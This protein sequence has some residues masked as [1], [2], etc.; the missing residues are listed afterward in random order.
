MEGEPR[1]SSSSLCSFFCFLTGDGVF[2]LGLNLLGILLAC[3][4]CLVA[5]SWSAS[6]S[7]QFISSSS[8]SVLLHRASLLRFF[9]VVCALFFCVGDHGSSLGGSIRRPGVLRGVLGLC[10]RLSPP[11]RQS[12]AGEIRQMRKRQSIFVHS[13]FDRLTMLSL[14]IVLLKVKVSP[15]ER[16]IAEE[17]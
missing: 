13:G 8:S 15:K 14:V 4:V 3:T 16:K 10:D 12:R 6:S 2:N 9:G 5:P 1:G 17:I 11:C 7:L